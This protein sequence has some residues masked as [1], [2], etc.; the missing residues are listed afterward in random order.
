MIDYHFVKIPDLT[1]QCSLS[2]KTIRGFRSLSPSSYEHKLH[3]T[4]NNPCGSCFSPLCDGI[5]PTPGFH[6][7]VFTMNRMPCKLSQLPK[8]SKHSFLRICQTSGCDGHL[9]CLHCL[10][11]T[12][13]GRMSFP[14]RHQRGCS[15]PQGRLPPK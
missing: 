5:L 9:G 6:P 8:K 4:L 2:S 15:A 11:N 7:T 12:W 3:P 10:V 1:P 14:E 13:D